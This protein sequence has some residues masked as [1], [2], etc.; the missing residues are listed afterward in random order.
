MIELAVTD[1]GIGLPENFDARRADTLGRK[2][3]SIY[4]QKLGGELIVGAGTKTVFQV[5]FPHNP[6]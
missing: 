1:D 6:S 3:I 4:A 5:W 2:L